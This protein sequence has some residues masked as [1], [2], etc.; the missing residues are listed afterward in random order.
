MNEIIEN[1][2]TRRSCRSFTTEKVNRKQVET[3]LN[4]AHYAP[5]GRNLQSWKFTA[6]L[7]EEL[8]SQLSTTI[9]RVLG[10]ENYSFYQA[11]AVILPSN[12]RDSKWGRDDNACAMQNMFLATN[13]MG[14]GS[15]WVNQLLDCCDHPEIRPILTKLGIPEDHVIYGIALVGYPKEQGKQVEKKSN[16]VI[17]E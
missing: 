2:L 6:L 17:I 13:S 11:T 8:I 14:L 5:S 10:R 16:Y 9:G 3:L 7:Q 1:I 15:L 12:Q 4:V